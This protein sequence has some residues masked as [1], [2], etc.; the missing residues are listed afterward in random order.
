[1]TFLVAWQGRE[2]VALEAESALPWLYGIATNVLRNQRRSL[3]RHRAALE[4]LPVERPEQLD[5][6]DETHERLDDAREMRTLLRLFVRLPRRE[7]DV[8]ALCDWSGLSY[9]EAARARRAAR[10]HPLPSGAR[11][12]PLPGTRSSE[13]TR[14]RRTGRFASD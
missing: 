5:F 14:T 2:K 13:R 9:E 10:H 1:V 7:Q 6:A 12:S 3:R 4:R 8:I 11:P